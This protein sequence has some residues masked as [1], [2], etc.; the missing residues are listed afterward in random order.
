MDGLICQLQLHLLQSCSTSL[1]ASK[2]AAQD[3]KGSEVCYFKISF[4][5]FP[6]VLETSSANMS[7]TTRMKM[8]L[9]SHENSDALFSFDTAKTHRLEVATT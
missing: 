3:S 5:S 4:A 6:T 7:N 9:I 2:M 1:A 8:A